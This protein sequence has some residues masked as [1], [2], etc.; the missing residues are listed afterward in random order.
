MNADDLRLFDRYCI[1]KIDAFG[2]AL[3]RRLAEVR[4]PRR[5]TP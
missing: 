1:V 3:I 5:P 2:W 4:R